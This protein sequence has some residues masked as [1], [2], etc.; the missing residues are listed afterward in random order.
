MSNIIQAEFFHVG[1]EDINSLEDLSAELSERIADGLELVLQGGESYSS[2]KTVVRFFDRNGSV[3]RLTQ[4]FE[5]MN[6]RKEA[7][8]KA[9]MSANGLKQVWLNFQSRY[10]V[11]KAYSLRK[12]A[13]HLAVQEFITAI[14][15]LNEIAVECVD[16]SFRHARSNEIHDLCERAQMATGIWLFIFKPNDLLADKN[17]LV[18]RVM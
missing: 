3:T 8:F 11:N 1:G 6:Q 15:K 10:Y 17:E 14:R 18:A 9:S 7:V 2:I 5:R 12:Q 4:K 16:H 13:E